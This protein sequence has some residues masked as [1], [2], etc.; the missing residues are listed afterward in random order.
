VESGHDL[1][2]VC[3][4]LSR[5]VRDIMMVMVDPA[6]AGEGDLAEGERAR[7]TALA[8][9]FSREDLMRAFDLL[10]KC[11]QDI[12]VAAHPRYH[13]EMAML[14]WMHLRRLV[15]LADLLEQMGSGRPAL[16][17]AGGSA[18]SVRRG[19]PSGPPAGEAK[20]SPLRSAAPSGAA[21]ASPHVRLRRPC[22]RAAGSRTRCW[23][24]SAAARRS[25][26]TPSSRRRS[27]S[28]WPATR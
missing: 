5:V 6:A 15:P 24:R 2:L 4:E 3:R 28:R 10:A 7:L 13:F 8:G 22:R 16:P 17:A 9:R 11:E 12:R 19:G 14:K 26:T 18:R 1:K 20:V 25:S 23:R 21:K 27:R